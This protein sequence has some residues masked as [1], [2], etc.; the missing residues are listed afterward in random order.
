MSRAIDPENRQGRDVE[1]AFVRQT[2]L[3]RDLV[4]AAGTDDV[5]PVRLLPWL[6]VVVLGGSTIVDRGRDVLVPLVDELR[7]LITSGDHRMLLLTG[8]G[9]RARHVLGVGLDLGLPAGALAGLAATEA[10]Q[11]GRLVA[12]LLAAEGVSYL[13]HDTVAG[14]LPVHLAAANAAVSNGYP[15]YGV[16]EFPATTGRLPVHRTDTGALLLADAYGAARLVYVRDA[17]SLAGLPEEVSAKELLSRDGDLPVDRLALEL[18]GVAKH[19]RSMTLVDG[20][21]PGALTGG[22][23]GR[24]GVTVTAV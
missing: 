23:A 8:A 2:L 12:S 4:R 22:L 5:A 1:S 17:A 18:L 11:N 3:D 20:T 24:G 15:P 19:V 9:I 21:T 13:P 14:Q 7:E 6:E 10:E 16:H